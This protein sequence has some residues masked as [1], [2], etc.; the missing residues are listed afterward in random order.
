MLRSLRHALG[1]QFGTLCLAAW[2]LTLIQYVRAA[3]QRMREQ[4][5]D[6]FLVA[7]FTMCMDFLYQIM[8]FITKFGVVRAAITGEGFWDA[9][10]GAVQ[11]LSRNL[12]DT[13][14]PDCVIVVE[15]VMLWFRC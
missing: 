14:S 7:C 3:L 4:N 10:R 15:V 6:S 2:L 5:S 13:V 8:A 9:S 1:P 12:L 11:L